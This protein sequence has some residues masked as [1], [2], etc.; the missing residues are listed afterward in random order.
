MSV[1]PDYSYRQKKALSDKIN[2][3]KNKTILTNV[4]KIIYSESTQCTENNNGIFVRFNNLSNKTYYMID[5][6][7]KEVYTKKVSITTETD[8]ETDP[9]KKRLSDTNYD[10]NLESKLRYSNKEKSLIKRQLY[11]S[12]TSDANVEYIPYETSSDS[13]KNKLSPS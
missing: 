6:Y 10:E 13:D 9:Y 5:S 3:I 4:F 11:E 8:S 1:V 2:R 12:L 7:L